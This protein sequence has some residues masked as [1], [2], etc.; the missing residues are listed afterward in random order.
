MEGLKIAYV[1][2]NSGVANTF[3]FIHGNSCSSAMWRKQFDSELLNNYRLIAIDLPGHGHSGFSNDP[4]VDYS[5]TGTSKILSQAIKKLAETNLYVLIGFSYGSNLAAEMLQ[6]DLKPNGIIL[7]GSCVLG[8]NFGLEKIFIQYDTPSIYLYNEPDELVVSGFLHK[9]IN[10]THE[11]DIRNLI[12]DYLSV[13]P[14]F[15]PALFKTAA[16]GKI[17]DEIFALNESNIPACVIFGKD[18]KLVNIDYLDSLPFPVWKNNIF[19]FPGAGHWV[20]IDNP[21]VFNK[22]IS[23]YAEEVFTPG[24]V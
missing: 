12:S 24:H 16:E 13:S 18:D 6:H 3:F 4:L 5:P 15:K 10:L 20:N 23:E 9:N 11:E 7:L 21:E 17:S 22:I 19:K 14:D 2:K 8:E 1:E